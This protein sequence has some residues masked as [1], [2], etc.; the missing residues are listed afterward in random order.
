MQI[1]HWN[2]THL[3]DVWFVSISWSNDQIKMKSAILCDDTRN[4]CKPLDDDNDD[5]DDE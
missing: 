3:P 5:D 1:V 2:L 4:N